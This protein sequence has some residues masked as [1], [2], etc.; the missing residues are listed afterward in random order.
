MMQGKFERFKCNFGTPGNAVPKLF[1]PVTG[2]SAGVDY[3][4]AGIRDSQIEISQDLVKQ[5]FDEQ[6]E[7]L[8]EL[9]EQQLQDLQ[10][11][12]PGEQVTYLFMS[13]GLCASPYIQARVRNYFELGAGGQISNARGLRVQLAEN[14]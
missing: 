13:G 9:I 7:G 3:P 4:H 11:S 6:A 10:R 2:L 1:L 5:L 14:M 8:I 12:R